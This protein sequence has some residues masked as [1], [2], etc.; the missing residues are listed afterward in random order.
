MLARE[1]VPP[2]SSPTRA[3]G[4]SNPHEN[5]SYEVPPRAITGLVLDRWFSR[6]NPSE[7]A[8]SYHNRAIV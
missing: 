8:A 2:A 3:E 5:L 6:A 7:R 1:Q 4:L